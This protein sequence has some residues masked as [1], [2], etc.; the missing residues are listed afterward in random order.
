MKFLLNM[1]LPRELGRR[2]IQHGY[3]CRHAA[4]IGLESASDDDILQE[5]RAH[6]EVIMTH[7]LDYGTLLAFSGDT[8]PSVIIFR[9]KKVSVEYL[10]E[11]LSQV[12]P[13]LQNDLTA[14]AI[15]IIEDAITRV[16]RLPIRQNHE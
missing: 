5:A 6:D 7:D 14:G 11:R 2:L 15:V 16:R 13:S 10:L 3:E 8:S 12:L 4:D 1:N 9:V